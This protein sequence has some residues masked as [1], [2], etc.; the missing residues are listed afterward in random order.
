MKKI[1]VALGL[2][3]I[4]SLFFGCAKKDGGADKPK[5]AGIVF[6]EDQFFRLILFGMRDAAEA[7]GAEFLEAN[8][9]NKPD[10]EIQLVNTYITRGIDAIAIS[11]ISSTASVTALKRAYD[12]GIK[13][14]IQN[15]PIESDIA[16]ATI[17]SDQFDLGASSGR[18]AKD[19]IEK[20]LGGKAKIAILAYTSQVPEQS[21]QRSGGFK[22]EVTKLPGVEIVAEQDAW[23][24]EMAVKKAGDILTANPDVNIIWAANEGGTVGSVM[25]VKNAGKAGEITVFGTD[26][27]EQ[28]IGFL[29][30]DTNIL[31]AIAGQ[32][33]YDIGRMSVEAALNA[34]KGNP[35]DKNVI[36]PA[37]VLN[38]NDP[39]GVKKFEA[40][41]K[42]LMSKGK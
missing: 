30:A 15:S 6:Q 35:V 40:D 37:F 42:E 25:A 19:Y 38:R 5:I 9:L 2:L 14:V 16:V 21:D 13:I 8:S 23:L 22:S 33:P 32:K 12:K 1:F 24:A 27:S 4:I 3:L 7:G 20:H 10:K 41:L 34:I 28:L 26:T 36:I 39:V 18:A 17:E 29:L 11:P 31:Q